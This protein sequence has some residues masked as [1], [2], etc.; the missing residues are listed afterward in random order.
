[1]C[2]SPGISVCWKHRSQQLELVYPGHLCSSDHSHSGRFGEPSFGVSGTANSHQ[3]YWPRREMA[4]SELSRPAPHGSWD[5]LRRTGDMQ[6]ASKLCFDILSFE[7]L[8][9]HWSVLPVH[10]RIR[11]RAHSC[12]D[13]QLASEDECARGH[14]EHV[15]AS[16]SPLAAAGVLLPTL[17]VMAGIASSDRLGGHADDVAD[18]QTGSCLGCPVGFLRHA[19]QRHVVHAQLQL[20][21]A[22]DFDG[23][24]LQQGRAD[25]LV[26]IPGHGVAT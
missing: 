2:A 20:S 17:S 16:V 11:H 21:V 23:W 8:R 26:H 9:G 22:R 14:H 4:T 13:T 25:V 12:E 5:L 1:M 3:V 18:Q 24:Q 6:Q 10:G 19:L 15:L 7:L